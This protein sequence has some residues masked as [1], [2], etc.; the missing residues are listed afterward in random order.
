MRAWYA[1]SLALLIGACDP[2]NGEFTPEDA[3]GVG[4]GGITYDDIGTICTYDPA[5]PMQHPSNTCPKSGMTCVIATRDGLYR[6]YGD[7]LYE[8]IPLFS[9]F[10]PDGKD[11][12]ICSMASM[13]GM[14]PPA[15]P[16]GTAIV[17]LSSGHHICMRLCDTSANCARDGYVC[18]YPFMD[19]SSY[20]PE[21]GA[22]AP[23]G[24][25][26]C[27]PGCQTD[28][29]YCMRTFHSQLGFHVYDGDLY[30]WRQC[31][32]VS[33][34]CED[35]V[36]RGAGYVG[37]QCVRSEHCQDNLLCI[38]GWL[39]GAQEEHG[40]CAR[41][42]NPDRNLQA[43]DNGCELGQGCEYFLNIAYCFPDC[44]A[45]QCGGANQVCNYADEGAAGLLPGQEWQRP[46]CIQCELSSL[47]CGAPTDAGV[48]TDS[49]VG[50]DAGS[51]D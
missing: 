13:P 19:G 49:A 48:G 1:A 5:N 6:E 27:V 2:G 15:C 50:V 28:L 7:F 24:L 20:N 11:E 45:M 21:T 9:R 22:V 30:G 4:P 40:F 16:Y 42:C 10:R 3:G 41:Y 34:L 31:N 32:T 43:P 46:H 33:G 17:M 12:G 35:V 44:S 39:F 8:A 51:P 47:E 37:S 26:L 14:P 18:D 36:A 23:L 38:G 29:P 25:Q